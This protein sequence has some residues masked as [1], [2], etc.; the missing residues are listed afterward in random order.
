MP[1]NL[2]KILV[3][4]LGAIGDVLMT[5]PSLKKLKEQYPHTSLHYLVGQWSQAVVKNHP[6][7][8]R[9]WVVNESWFYK[10]NVMK[11][12]YLFVLLLRQ[13]YDRVYL[14]H[15]HRSYHYY[16][17]FVSP[18]LIGPRTSR[19]FMGCFPWY[20]SS[21]AFDDFEIKHHAHIFLKL[22]SGFPPKKPQ[23]RRLVSHGRHITVTQ[24]ISPTATVLEFYTEENI[25][26]SIENKLKP[27]VRSRKPLIFINPGGGT[28]PGETN[29][30]KQWME[31]SYIELVL[32]RHQKSFAENY[33][34]VGGPTDVSLCVSIQ[35]KI[36]QQKPFIPLLNL[37]G[38]CSLQVFRRI[39]E[40]YGHLF[41]TGDTGGM[42]VASTVK[43]LAIVSLFGATSAFSFGPLSNGSISIQS[44]ISCSPCYY[45]KFHGCANP[46]CVDLISVEVVSKAMT[47]ALK[48]CSNYSPSLQ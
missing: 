37:A 16:F 3:V 36:H 26:L 33:C 2:K 10:K 29:T 1:T 23:L 41:L 42:H 25:P 39:L 45:G 8:D 6:C 40:K 27:S 30:V 46:I 17:H 34:L 12:F 28:N 19:L 43:G 11:L 13:R 24:V 31:Q 4:K 32:L 38:S 15:R 20:A 48:Q 44:T 35:E 7:V 22:V 14:L 47:R 9:L 18:E 5:T 21:D